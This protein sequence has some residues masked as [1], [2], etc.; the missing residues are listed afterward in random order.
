MAV[1]KIQGLQEV[2][3]QFYL[4]VSPPKYIVNTNDVK[5]KAKEQNFVLACA[6][7]M[8]VHKMQLQGLQEVLKQFYLAVSPP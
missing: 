2:L 5:V 3:K 1:D 7:L 4:A 6:F 8:V